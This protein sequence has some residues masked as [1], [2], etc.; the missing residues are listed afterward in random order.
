VAA[1]IFRA[2]K[3]MERN[4]QSTIDEVDVLAACG[5]QARLGLQV[6]DRHLRDL[7]SKSVLAPR[8]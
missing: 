3:N 6:E 2:V 4:Q 5:P 7:D 1:L 8:Q